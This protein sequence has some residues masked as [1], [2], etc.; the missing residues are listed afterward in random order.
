MP[1]AEEKT[2]GPA[3]ISS[4]DFFETIGKKAGHLAPTP[5]G[6]NGTNGTNG[7]NG[8]HENGGDNEKIVEEIES[9]CMNCH[10]NVSNVDTGPGFYPSYAVLTLNDYLGHDAHAP[11][12]YSLFPR[13]H[14]HVL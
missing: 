3:P 6:T 10:E 1:A 11:D 8:A 4:N 7:D 5:N 9:L 13:N 12:R 2:N 14:R